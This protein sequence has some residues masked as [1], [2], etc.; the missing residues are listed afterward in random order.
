LSLFK[1][2]VVYSSKTGNTKK[3]AE[4]IMKVLPG[5][6]DI[7][8]VEKAPDPSEYDFIAAGFWVDRGTAETKALEY[9]KKIE[10]KKVAIF[11]TLGAYPDSA[12]AEKVVENAKKLFGEKNEVLGHFICQG[13]IDP[14]LTEKFKDLPP[15][16]PHA[17]T[18]ERKARHEEAKK[19]PDSKDF[20]NACQAFKGIMEE[21]F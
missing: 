15:D 18:P 12:H 1:T 8:P 3:V 21:N 5:N 14:A 6:T 7:F 4:E 10:N 20:K 11:I 2:M 17:M 9:F 13:K 19:H 16:H